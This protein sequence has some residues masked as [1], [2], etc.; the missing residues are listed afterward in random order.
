MRLRGYEVYYNGASKI[1]K[2]NH[3]D[4]KKMY[5]SLPESYMKALN[6]ILSD[7]RGLLYR[8]TIKTNVKN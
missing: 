5:D 2:R 4:A 3:W 6:K 8:K 1:F 7:D